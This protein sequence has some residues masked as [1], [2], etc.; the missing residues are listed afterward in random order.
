[1]ISGF[2]NFL[3]KKFQAMKLSTE[4][5]IKLIIFIVLGIGIFGYGIYFIGKKSNLFGDT[6]TISGVFRD[7]S[8][9]KIGNNVRFSGINVGTVS[10]IKLINDTLVQVDVTVET[11]TQKFIRKNSKME[12]G[13]DGLMGSKVIKITPGTT[14]SPTVKEG[15]VLETV[16]AIQIDNIMKELKKSSV[17]TSKITSNLADITDK[18][19]KGEGI[20]GSLFTD[21]NLSRNLNDISKNTAA[22]TRN[23]NTITKKINAEEGVL[24]KLLSDTSISDQ[25][26]ESSIN[27]SKS[28]K[29]LNEITKKINQGEGVFGKLY[30]DTTFTQNLEETTQ[31]LNYTT[32]QAQKIADDMKAITG[33]IRNGKGVMHKLLV[34]SAFADSLGKTL[35]NIDKSAKELDEAAE[36]VRKNWF[37]KTFSSKKRDDRKNRKQQEK[38]EKKKEKEKKSNEG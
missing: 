17:N 18:I 7:V 36:T 33:F 2:N 6:F 20:F 31:N 27:L 21:R 38:E 29:N 5:T 32:K 23:F 14:D 26:A 4:R 22:L 16:E 25:F 28:I 12:I 37:I 8:G 11:Q 35:Y 30:T 15:D 24:G 34:D 10:E 9:L 3:P 19:N 13:T 1:M